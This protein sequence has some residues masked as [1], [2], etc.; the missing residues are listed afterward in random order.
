MPEPISEASGM[1]ATQPVSSSCFAMIGS[2]EQYTITSK[3]S[4]TSV[5]GGLQRL[6]HVRVERVRVAQHFELD[7]VVPV[8]ELARE[9]QRAHGVGRAVAAGGIRQV[10][11]LRRGQRIEQARLVGILADVGAPNRDR[12]DLGAAGVDRRARL[13]EV[14]VLAGADQQARGVGLARDDER[15]FTQPPPTATTISSWSP[16]ASTVPACAL[17]GTISPFRSRRPLAR[18]VS[19]GEQAAN[20][21][22]ALEAGAS[23]FTS[24]LDHPHY[25]KQPAGSKSSLLC[26]RVRRMRTCGS[27][28]QVDDLV[29]LQLLAGG[30]EQQH[31]HG[32]EALLAALR[33]DHAGLAGG[34]LHP[35]RPGRRRRTGCN[36]STSPRVKAAAALGQQDGRGGRR[37][38]L[39]GIGPRR[40]QRVVG[41]A[42]RRDA[43]RTA[44][45]PGT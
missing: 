40:H 33:D 32:L 22:R 13:G 37:R 45:S 14:L 20:V 27:R 4:L 41:V 23:P 6:R 39:L 10:G 36:C 38:E 7:Q 26:S 43:S 9:A 1:T 25:T 8:E 16:S 3:P 31:D 30:I 19:F 11:V 44:R 12:D 15:V 17:L 29:R 24:D 28:F 21:D 35:R 2:S 18:Q 34:E 42:D 5:F